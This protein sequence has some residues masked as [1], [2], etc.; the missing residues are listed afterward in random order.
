MNLQ[1]YQGKSILK[2]H[3]VKIQ[4]GYVAET[5]GEAKQIAEKLKKEWA[6]EENKQ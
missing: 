1:E 6:K 3:G 4:E 2:K 5:S